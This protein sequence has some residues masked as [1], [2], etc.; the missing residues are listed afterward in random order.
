LDGISENDYTNGVPGSVVGLALGVDA[1]QEF[2]VVTNSY[3]ATYGG[4]SGGV[5]NA[6]TR[7]G[8]NQ[9]HGDAFEFL[10]NDTLDA[11]TFFV[12]QKP[13]FRR[14]QFGV[15]AGAP[16]RRDKTFI[17]ANFEGLRQSLTNTSIA[18]VP[19]AASRA[20]NLS[21]GKVT[22][23]PAIVP[24]L[25][26]WP[27]P[28]GSLLGPGDIGQYLFTARSPSS[29]NSGSVRVDNVVSAKDSVAVVY[30]VD[31]GDT[32]VPDGLNTIFAD[33]T[34]RRNTASISESHI[35]GPQ[36]LNAFRFGMNRVTAHA[37]AT[38][39]GM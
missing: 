31:D 2:S 22:V 6:V 5:V 34:L 14:N 28:N 11:R 1:I 13:P 8:T 23:S 38:S 21:T 17:F 10:R 15:A 29:E 36:M 33:S 26:L 35:F 9:F 24:Y 3:N 4:T 18:T 39:P 7:S 19:S 27:L 16:I 37:L 32:H 30:S 25:A 12:I 20:G